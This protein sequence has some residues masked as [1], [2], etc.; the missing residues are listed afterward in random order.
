MSNPYEAPTIVGYNATPPANDGT[1]VSANQLDWDKHLDKIGGPLKVFAEA[2]NTNVLAAFGDVFGSAVLQK[3]IDYTVTTADIGRFI[4]V[5]GTTTITLLSAVDAG[6][7]FPLAIVNTGTGI[8]TIETTDSETFNGEITATINPGGGA[9]VSSTGAAW[10]GLN[11]DANFSKGSF[12]P[13]FTGFSSGPSTPV[14]KWSKA[15]PLVFVKLLFG[16]GTS[17]AT[18]FS[19]TNWPTAIFADDA[20]LIPVGGL[21]D[22]G[23]E[24][25]GGCISFSAASATVTFY[26]DFGFSLWT[27][28]GA[29]GVNN[30]SLSSCFTYSTDLG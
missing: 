3:S 1:E 6:V 19:I 12:T 13:T 8:V 9:L 15:G 24:L 25:T 16:T 7:G 2:I 4:S 18:G 28:S 26:T 22:N 11:T 20:L 29:K 14:V 21:I 30:T 27:A 10:F 5:T 17:D 23:T